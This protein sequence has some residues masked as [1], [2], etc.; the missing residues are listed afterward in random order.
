[1][2]TSEIFSEKNIKVHELLA[3]CIWF[4]RHEPTQSQIEELQARGLEI[5]ALEDGKKVGELIIANNTDLKIVCDTLFTLCNIH[6][7]KHVVG[8][9]P[10]PLIEMIARSSR[11]AI[12]LGIVPDDAVHCLQS[13][14]VRRDSVQ[15]RSSFEHMRFCSA[16]FLLPGAM[17]WVI[18]DN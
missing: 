7:A 6:Q 16:G 2:T 3:N 18:N 5:A 15:G 14:N 9:F 10:A 1:M 4:S 8:V 11:D 12:T 13:W 17:R